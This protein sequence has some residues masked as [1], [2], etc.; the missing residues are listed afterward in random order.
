MVES[1]P[2]GMWTRGLSSQPR[3]R[4]VLDP[5]GKGH[6]LGGNNVTCLAVDFLKVTHK[7]QHMVIHAAHHR[8]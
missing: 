2:L 5:N 4:L 3:V 6:F 7:G 8:Y 1:M